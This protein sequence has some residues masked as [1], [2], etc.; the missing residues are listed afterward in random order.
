[1]VNVAKTC[2]MHSWTLHRLQLEPSTRSRRP[3]LMTDPSLPM[4]TVNC[5]ALL[6]NEPTNDLLPADSNGYALM[7]PT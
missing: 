4:H 3:V 1:M 6:T 5:S 2:L 7:H